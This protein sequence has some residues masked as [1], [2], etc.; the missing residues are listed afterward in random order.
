MSWLGI[1]EVRNDL[2]ELDKKVNDVY[3]ENLDYHKKLNALAL[4][5]AQRLQE[6]EQK[7]NSEELVLVMG[8]LED[9]RKKV[10]E[11]KVLIDEILMLLK[12]LALEK[13]LINAPKPKTTEE[14]IDDM[15]GRFTN[16]K[17][18]TSE[19]PEAE[20]D[21]STVAYCLGCGKIRRMKPGTIERK[22]SS[23]GAFNIGE[24]EV[25]GRKIPKKI[26]K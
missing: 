9:L 24:C 11:Y 20:I 2:V 21:S 4:N 12:R 5:N 13:N 17:S 19:V 7:D 15:V 16:I 1:E 3:T 14:K 8:E 25:C 26:K 22:E 23:K 18:E 6:I 10:N